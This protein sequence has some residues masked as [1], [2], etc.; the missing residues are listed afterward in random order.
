MAPLFRRAFAGEA[1]T[2]EPIP[3]TLDR[4]E[5]AGRAPGGARVR[6]PVKDDAGRVEEVVLVTATSP[7]SGRG[8]GCESEGGC[9]P[10]S[11]RPRRASQVDLTER[12]VLANRRYCRSSAARRELPN[13]QMQDIPHPDDLPGNLALLE[14][15]VGNGV[16][17]VIE[18]VTSGHDGSD[19][20]VSNSVSLLKDRDGR[21]AGL[22]AA[23]VD[24]TERQ[25]RAEEALRESEGTRGGSSTTRWR[26]SG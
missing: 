4:G 1:V 11:S 12:Y 15:A 21:A 19:V 18:S 2:I 8:R 9:R 23:T 20:W 17:F 22:L 6:L 26:S 13:L 7:N 3:Y 5:H 24:I 16:P 10:S 14:K 25:A